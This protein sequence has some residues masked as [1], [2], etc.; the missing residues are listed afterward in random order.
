MWRK[1]INQPLKRGEKSQKS[2]KCWKQN[3]KDKKKLLQSEW[4]WGFIGFNV[5]LTAHTA[6]ILLTAGESET[7]L[8]YRKE[9]IQNLKIWTEEYLFSWQ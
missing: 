9:Q 4:F 5:L 3:L 8:P 2:L 1:W 6:P 7:G